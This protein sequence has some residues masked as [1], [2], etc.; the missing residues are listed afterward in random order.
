MPGQVIYNLFLEKEVS[1][2]C[3]S[4]IEYY[5]VVCSDMCISEQRIDWKCASF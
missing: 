2:G 5:I 4:N 3:A 1:L